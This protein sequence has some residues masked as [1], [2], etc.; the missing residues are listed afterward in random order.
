L[1][2]TIRAIRSAHLL[3]SVAERENDQNAKPNGTPNGNK[4]GNKN[5]NLKLLEPIEMYH[6]DQLVTNN[7]ITS[8][9]L[10]RKLTN[11][12]HAG[13]HTG[14]KTLKRKKKRKKMSY[15]RMKQYKHIN[16]EY[17]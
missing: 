4:N 9:A 11:G 10:A 15:K 8:D 7:G 17:I 12:N 14:G 16:K 13:N 5:G 1:P 3:A 6:N 2:V